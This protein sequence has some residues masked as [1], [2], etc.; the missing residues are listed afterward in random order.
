VQYERRRNDTQPY[1]NYGAALSDTTHFTFA[2]LDQTTLA[3]VARAN[4]TVTPTLS[5]QLYAQPFV[6]SGAFADWRELADPTA[7]AY[8][9]RF[10]SFSRAGT[11]LQ[12]YNAKQFNST[13]VLRWEYR[14]GST[15][16]LVW[17]QGR[18]DGRD[19]GTFEVTRDLRRLF[20]THPD[21]TVLVKFSYWMTP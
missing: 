3:M 1:A 19:P 20:A 18:A 5:L 16:F 12:G 15:L 2:R 9:D 4:V 7:P 11:T 13:M 6:A 14:L 8:A 10:R 17:Q 21:N